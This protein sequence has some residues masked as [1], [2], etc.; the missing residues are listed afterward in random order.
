MFGKSVA[1][2]EKKRKTFSSMLQYVAKWQSDQ[3]ERE[4]KSQ[5]AEER[6]RK[7]KRKRL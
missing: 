6:E 2:A 3:K 1:E 5:A 7:R 4:G